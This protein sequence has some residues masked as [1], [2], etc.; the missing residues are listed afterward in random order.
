[1]INCI[2]AIDNFESIIDKGKVSFIPI[3]V[4]ATIQ[5]F[6]EIDDNNQSYSYRIV[7]K[8]KTEGYYVISWRDGNL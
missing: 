2:D 5:A 7:L 4:N 8:P 3:C 1:M 6:P